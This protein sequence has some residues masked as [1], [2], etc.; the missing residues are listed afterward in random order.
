MF[1]KGEKS[2][3]SEE[4]L[5]DK[6]V[7]VM[8]GDTA[9]EYAVKTKLSDRLILTDTFEEALR[10]LSSGKHDAVII[11]Q[12][13]GIQLIKQLNISNLI[14]VGTVQNTNLKP[15]ARPLKGFEQKF[16]IAVQEGDKAFAFSF[17]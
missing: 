8:R 7:L 9:H 12:L 11:Q 4:D 2:I 15:I 1:E 16:C 3:H 5:K 13:A 10:M 14:D 17:E 6:E